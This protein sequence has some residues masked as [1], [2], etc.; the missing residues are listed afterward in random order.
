MREFFVR[1]KERQSGNHSGCLGD[2]GLRH[3]DAPPCRSA[4]KVRQNAGLSLAT[5]LFFSQVAYLVHDNL[6]VLMF[7]TVLVGPCVRVELTCEED[8]LSFLEEIP[9]DDLLVVVE[10]LL[11]DNATEEACL[12]AV[13]GEVLRECEACE[14]HSFVRCHVGCKSA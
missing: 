4:C 11:E 8:F 6:D 9:R 3:R 2:R 13:L 5:R 14:S 1:I 10:L 12:F 7:G